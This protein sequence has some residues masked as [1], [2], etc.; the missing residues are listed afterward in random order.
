MRALFLALALAL[1]GTLRGEAV[2]AEAPDVVELWPE[3]SVL[4]AGRCL[5]D[6]PARVAALPASCFMPASRRADDR[7]AGWFRPHELWLRLRAPAAIAVNGPWALRLSYMVD[8]GKLDVFSPAG[9]LVQHALV[10][11]EIPVAQRAIHSYDDRIPIAGAVQP[12]D[13][14]VLHL[15]ATRARFEIL[16]LRNVEGL[17]ALDPPAVKHVDD[18][19]VF[20]LGMLASMAI[21]NLLWYALLGG[22]PFLLYA[23]AMGAMIF[24]QVVQSGAAWELIWPHAAVRDDA[25]AYLAYVFYFLFVVAFARSFL[26][27]PRTSPWADRM[28]LA[29]FALLAGEALLYIIAPGLVGSLG[30]WD[31]VDP[32]VVAVMSVALLGAGGVAWL[33]GVQGARWYTLALAGAGVGY[34]IADAIDFG[35]IAST[36][37]G[38]VWS[39]LGVVWEALLFAVALALRVRSVQQ[40]AA[41]LSEFAYLDPLTT[42]ANRRAFDDTM[43]REWRRGTRTA[44]PL[45][46]V[47]FD[48]DRFKAYND[49]FG[50]QAGDAILQRIA[51]EIASA[52][53]RSGDFAARYGGEE[54]ALILPETPPDGALASAE[55]VRTAI[56]ALAIPHEDGTVT[57]SAGIATV[58]PYDG[59]TPKTLIA[60]ADRALYQAKAAGRNCTVVAP[61]DRTLSPPVTSRTSPD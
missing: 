59:T 9:R 18:R 22:T 7:G 19:I 20:L 1:A 36:D 35:L 4:V 8:R 32:I 47:F 38:E 53:R 31:I 60:A 46:L 11:M 34:F 15:T 42:I 57:I 25:V 50:H 58:V 5:A 28:V 39:A 6:G 61:P 52:A 41:Q 2:A 10:G 26:D 56:E 16:E 33:H 29:A 44:R 51:S 27:L 12:G 24:F 45:S 13:T 37:A 30:L 49:C 3:A 21:F 14:V 55:N 23:L 40:H 54:F 17:A 43:R 48:I